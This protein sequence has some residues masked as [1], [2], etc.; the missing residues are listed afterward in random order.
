LKIDPEQDS[1]MSRHNFFDVTD[2]D[3]I[4]EYTYPIYAD[5]D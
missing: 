1:L 4:L 3:W 5:V 2:A